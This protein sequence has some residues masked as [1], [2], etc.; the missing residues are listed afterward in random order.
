MIYSGRSGLKKFEI[1]V[2]T[3]IWELAENLILIFSDERDDKKQMDH[4]KRRYA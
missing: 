4:L 3:R 1:K 2:Y